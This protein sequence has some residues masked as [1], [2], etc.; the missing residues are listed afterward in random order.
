MTY[1]SKVTI[2]K[3]SPCPIGLWSKHSLCE[4]DILNLLLN[5]SAELK[6]IYEFLSSFTFRYSNKKYQL[7]ESL[8][9]NRIALNFK[10]LFN[11]LKRIKLISK[12]RLTNPYTNSPI[13]GINNKIKFINRIIFDYHRC[14]RQLY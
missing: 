6:A 12:N 14:I 11:P 4:I 10:Q 7:F 2:Y 3:C 13:E 8:T 9:R 1:Q 5:L